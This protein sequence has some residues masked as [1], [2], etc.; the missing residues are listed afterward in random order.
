[1][2]IDDAVDNQPKI[3]HCVRI[4]NRWFSQTDQTQ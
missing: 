1:M 3:G 4:P 2:T